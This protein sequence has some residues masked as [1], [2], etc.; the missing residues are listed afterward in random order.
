L[1]IKLA[2]PQARKEIDTIHD[3]ESQIFRQRRRGLCLSGSTGEQAIIL[4]ARL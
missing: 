3:S 2:T 1:T 4:G